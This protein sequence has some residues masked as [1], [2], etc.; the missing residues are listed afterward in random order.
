MNISYLKYI[1]K[2]AKINKNAFN[3]YK[4]LYACFKI[5]VIILHF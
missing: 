2:F 5:F 3:K 4:Y 1:I